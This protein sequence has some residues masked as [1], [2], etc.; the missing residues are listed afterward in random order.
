[1]KSLITLLLVIISSVCYSQKK[2]S[3]IEELRKWNK[4]VDSTETYFNGKD[5]IDS[6]FIL[7]NE[8][9]AENEVRPLILTN[10]LCDVAKIQ[11]QYCSD[12]LIVTH[13]QEDDLLESCYQRGWKYG[14]YAVTGEVIAE[15]SIRSMLLKNETISSSPINGLKLSKGHSHIMK[16]PEYVKCGI[17]IVQSD[18]DKNSYFT[19][20]VFSEE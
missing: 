16:K 10:S 14:E 8:Y 17:S 1:M 20:I 4:L 12:N 11:S 13:K 19:V 7:L 2:I 9:R 15:R 18:K 6:V 5:N 3:S